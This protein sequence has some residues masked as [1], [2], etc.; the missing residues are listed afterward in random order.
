MILMCS[1]SLM[2]N[3]LWMMNDL[4]MMLKLKFFVSSSSRLACSWRITITR[5][6]SI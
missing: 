1:L 4:R 6:T 2:I 5:T 3:Y